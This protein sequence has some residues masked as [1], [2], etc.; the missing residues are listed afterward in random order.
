[1]GSFSDYLEKEILDH[2]FKVGAYT[3]PTNIFVALCKTTPDDDDTGTDIAGKEP[4]GGDYARVTCNTWNVADAGATANTGAIT[5]AEA[6]ADWGTV[7]GFAILD[8]AATGN[9]LAW[10]TLTTSKAIDTGDTAS[11]AAGDIDITLT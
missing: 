7:L 1:M 6:S 2:I 4:S 3:Q 11:F 10:G 5:F 8:H 9:M